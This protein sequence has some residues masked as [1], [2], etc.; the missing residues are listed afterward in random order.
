MTLKFS[1]VQ[2]WIFFQWR[3]K[4]Q[5]I[6]SR[7]R[8]DPDISVAQLASTT[9]GGRR[10]GPSLVVVREPTSNRGSY[11]WSEATKQAGAATSAS[12]RRARSRSEA[13][14]GG[15]LGNWPNPDRGLCCEEVNRQQRLTDSSKTLVPICM[16]WHGRHGAPFSPRAL[17]TGACRPFSPGP[18]FLLAGRARAAPRC[19]HSIMVMDGRLHR[20][21]SATYCSIS[22]VAGTAM[23][24]GCVVTHRLYSFCICTVYLCRDWCVDRSTKKARPTHSMVQNILLSG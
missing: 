7:R 3:T 11:G 8:G 24:T 19:V 10:G 17:H 5:K 21:P 16:T 18:Y 20:S 14:P 13:Q 4:I 22:V 1:R 9:R 12:A 15:Q 2:T 23:A 6:R